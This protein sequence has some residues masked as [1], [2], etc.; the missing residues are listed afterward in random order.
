MNLLNR[1]S[2][3]NKM[4]VLLLVATSISLG[5]G[6]TIVIL[7]DVTD[8][9]RDMKEGGTT[10]ARVIADYSVVDLAFEDRVASKKTLA[11]LTAIPEVE[12][13]FLY[14]ASGALFSSYNRGHCASEPGPHENPMVEFDGHFLHVY[15]PVTE[16]HIMYGSLHLCLSTKGLDQKIRNYLVTILSLVGALILLSFLLAII[17]QKIISRPLLDLAQTTRKISQRQDYS[18]RVQKSSEDEIGALCDEF[19][20]MLSQ[21]QKRQADRETAE[22]ALRESE[23]RY[24]VLVESSPEAVFLEQDGKIVYAN[25]QAYQLTGIRSLAEMEKYSLAKLFRTDSPDGPAAPGSPAVET[26]LIRADGKRLEVEVTAVQTLYQ[27][28]S[29][30]QALVRDITESKNLRKAAERMNRLASLGEF[31]ATLSHEVRN[32]LASI[33]LN[34][35]TLAERLEIPEANMGT[36]RN[37]EL[38]VEEI[39]DLIKGILDFAR[40][41]PPCLRKLKI[42]K[43]LES[44]VRMVENEMRRA[45]IQIVCDFDPSDPDVVVDPNQ[46]SQVFINLLLNA[47][48]AMDSGGDITLRTRNM[49]RMIQVQVMDTGK[50]ISPENLE[51]IFDPFFTTS[52]TGVGLGLAVVSRI[53]EQHQAQV[54]VESKPSEG[55]V[56]TVLFQGE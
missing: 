50:G 2:I 30:N 56:F 55:T 53:L 48:Q 29:A 26:S 28:R 24:R 17:L 14:D 31:S 22:G 12:C 45:G 25:P 21:I 40:P 23:Y 4:I 10:I 52:P 8:L 54:L 43:V 16:Q 3:R 1:F 37:M 36:F 46:I 20:N 49:G 33:S 41:A 44:S 38:G 6:F 34:M 35:R 39:Q 9:E 18:I 27:G 15:E 7:H 42:H 5:T 51:R 13:A 32:S 19:N 11:R 47:K